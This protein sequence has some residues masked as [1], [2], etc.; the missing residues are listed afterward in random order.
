MYTIMIR[1]YAQRK[2][3]ISN[4]HLEGELLFV[5]TNGENSA[6]RDISK[7]SIYIYKYIC[8]LIKYEL[9]THIDNCKHFSYASV[10]E[11]YNIYLEYAFAI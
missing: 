3:V 11:Q 5:M 2:L 7:Q 6:S 10:S 9:Y 8:L 4:L 1:T